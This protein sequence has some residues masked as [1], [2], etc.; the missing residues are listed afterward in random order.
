[1][2]P[3]E[4][5]Q[6]MWEMLSDAHKQTM[7]ANGFTSQEQKAQL[8]AGFLG[9]VTGAM[10]ASLGRDA[11]VVYDAVGSALDAVIDETPKLAIV[12]TPAQN[13]GGQ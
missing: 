7:L 9:G 8:W 10:G 6:Q 4:C 11:R 13:G 3:I 12:K 5:G 1:M 2:T